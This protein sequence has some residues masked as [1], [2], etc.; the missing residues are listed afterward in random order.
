MDVTRV[1]IHGLESS[2]RGTK[3]VFFRDRYPDMII[4]DFGGPLEARMKQLD[5]LLAGLRDLC[6]VGSSFGG[7]M[8]AIYACENEPRVRKVVLLAPAL[9][10]PDFR[11]FLGRRVTVPV[12]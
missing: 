12:S 8:A 6:L 5:G 3:G 7:L 11:R 4:E 2:S 10:V 9:H 1:F